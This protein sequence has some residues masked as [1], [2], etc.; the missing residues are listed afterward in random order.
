[1]GMV[2]F[3]IQREFLSFL[4]IKVTKRAC[5]VVHISVHLV[6]VCGSLLEEAISLDLLN[7]VVSYVSLSPPPATFPLLR[8]HRQP[9]GVSGAIYPPFSSILARSEWFLI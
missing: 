4:Q 9:G 5:P 8:Y 7:V 2:G 3:K 1:M 6:Q